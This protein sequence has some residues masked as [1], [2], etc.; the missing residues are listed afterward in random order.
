MPFVMSAMVSPDWSPR[1]CVSACVSTFSMDGSWPEAAASKSHCI[2][3]MG[4]PRFRARSL[5]IP[6][7]PSQSSKLHCFVNSTST[8]APVRTVSLKLYPFV[9]TPVPLTNRLD[10]SFNPEY[11]CLTKTRPTNLQLLRTGNWTRDLERAEACM[12][13]R[14]TDPLVVQTLLD[15]TLRAHN[16]SK[17]KTCYALPVRRA[18][19]QSH[20]NKVGRKQVVCLVKPP[21]AVG[22]EWLLQLVTA[23]GTQGVEAFAREDGLGC[24]RS[25]E[26]GGTFQFGRTGNS[27]RDAAERL[28]RH[29]RG[30][31]FRLLAVEGSS[32][33][34]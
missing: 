8:S 3:T 6:S 29:A 26:A 4:T 15:P 30:C 31:R 9:H 22:D 5:F 21:R 14:V 20:K 11:L 10:H 27:R 13:V 17:R 1:S 28:T 19:G 23:G 16:C 32:F 34:V 2:G 12:L 25:R 18:L 7:G 24:R 33:S